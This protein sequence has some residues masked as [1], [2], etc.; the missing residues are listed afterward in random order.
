M[1]FALHHV[2]IKREV[3]KKIIDIERIPLVTLPIALGKA[4]SAPIPQGGRV[5]GQN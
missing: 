2:Y 4:V 3:L 1:Y 5:V